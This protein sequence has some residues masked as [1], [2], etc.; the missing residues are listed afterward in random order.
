MLIM[1]RTV[2]IVIMMALANTYYVH[3]V[4]KVVFQVSSSY[5]VL[6]LILTIIPLST[7]YLSLIL[8][9]RDK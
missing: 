6:P 2:K 3:A 8:Q 5:T 4:Y 7:Y 1:M 9:L